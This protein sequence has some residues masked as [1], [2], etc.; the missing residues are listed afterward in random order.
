MVCL[1]GKEVFSGSQYLGS[2]FYMMLELD[3]LLRIVK[4][5]L[6]QVRKDD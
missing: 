4:G 3:L 2:L 1:F 6:A 5:Q